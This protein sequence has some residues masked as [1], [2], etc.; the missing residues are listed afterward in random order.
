MNIPYCLRRAEMMY[1]DQ[2]AV[3]ENDRTITYREFGKG[4]RRGAARLHAMG[5]ARGDRVAVLM[6]NSALYYELY[7]S[8]PIAGALIVPV[9][10]RWNTEDVL[11][12]LRDSGSKMLLVDERFVAMAEEIRERIPELVLGFA[13]SGDCPAGFQDYRLAAQPMEFPEPGPEDL[14]G[15]FYTSGTTGGPKGVMLTHRNVCAHTLGSIL[16]DCFGPFTFL[17]CL[18]MFHI[19][20]AAPCFPVMLTGGKFHFLPGF[21]PQ[22][23]LEA[24][25]RHRIEMMCL[26][27]SMWAMLLNHPDFDRFDLSSIKKVIW[28]AA[29]MPIA[30][31]ELLMHKLPGR[32]CTEA[33]GLTE[34]SGIATIGFR[35]QPEDHVGHPACSVEV[36][37]V[38]DDDR[39]LPP[40]EAGEV[41]IRGD[42][43]MKGY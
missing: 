8:M 15:L 16:E 11:F 38:D 39:P 20:G 1:G 35:G 32:L 33:Y 18:P 37:V 28:A 43:V 2:P 30:L 4:V 3:L 21:D 22:A 17:Q 41:V 42:T 24:I 26:V 25:E 31:Q 10:T 13:G 19:A 12:V 27:P 36:R 5:I 9:N 23:V 40:G 29:P 14:L 34:A 7:F 6:A